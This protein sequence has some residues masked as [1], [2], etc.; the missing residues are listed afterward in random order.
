M[1]QMI[2]HHENAVNMARILLNNPG[3]GVELDEEVSEKKNALDAH[4]QDDSWYSLS[5][6]HI[7]HTSL[8]PNA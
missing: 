3:D 4:E 6:F 2:P 5:F 8:T 7:C 1:H